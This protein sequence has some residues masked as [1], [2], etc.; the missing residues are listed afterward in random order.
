MLTRLLHCNFGGC[1]PNFP[2]L[3]VN[4]LHARPAHDPS[5]L[6]LSVTP[7]FATG[8]RGSRPNSASTGCSPRPH[9]VD[10]G[11]ARSCLMRR[12]TGRSM[13][14]SWVGPAAIARVSVTEPPPPL[15]FSASPPSATSPFLNRLDPARPSWTLG[16]KG[17][18]GCLSRM[19]RRSRRER[20]RE[21]RRAQRAFG[22]GLRHG[23]Y[24]H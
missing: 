14:M 6:G 23:L 16:A 22:M 1:V 11:S 18:F 5:P 4:L 20:E 10:V 19:S 12:A 3:R 24:R 17:M 7:F 8:P 15:L 2:A 9:T 21:R 13:D